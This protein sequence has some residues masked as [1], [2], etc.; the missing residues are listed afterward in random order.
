MKDVLEEMEED[1]YL[2][3]NKRVTLRRYVLVDGREQLFINGMQQFD[4]PHAFA[5]LN[6]TLQTSLVCF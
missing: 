2:V 4:R 6:S 3:H 5:H 1:K